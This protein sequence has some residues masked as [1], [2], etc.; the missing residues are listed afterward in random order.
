MN[1]IKRGICDSLPGA[2]NID[3]LRAAFPLKKLALL[4]RL[5]KYLKIFHLQQPTSIS[6]VKSI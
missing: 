4:K 6:L 2:Q 3:I 1:N 5:N